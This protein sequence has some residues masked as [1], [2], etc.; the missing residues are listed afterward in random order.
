[1]S[2]RIRQRGADFAS[3]SFKGSANGLF[4]LKRLG[5][6]RGSLSSANGTA[7]KQKRST[8]HNRSSRDMSSILSQSHAKKRDRGDHGDR[9]W[10]GRSRCVSPGKAAVEIPP[11]NS[12]RPCFECD[13]HLEIQILLQNRQAGESFVVCDKQVHR[14]STTFHVTGSFFSAPT[15]TIRGPA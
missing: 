10:D 13:G 2:G 6:G 14:D 1:M 7:K 12:G 5:R 11:G 8:P 9:D 4:S 15:R 3:L